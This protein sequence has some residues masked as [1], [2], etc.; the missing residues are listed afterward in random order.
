[1]IQK[2][3]VSLTEAIEAAE[4]SQYFEEGEIRLIQSFINSNVM[5]NNPEIATEK[6]D[7]RAEEEDDNNNEAHLNDQDSTGKKEKRDPVRELFMLQQTE[8]KQFLCMY[9]TILMYFSIN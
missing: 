9:S 6:I 5:V 3:S 7:Y 1:M 8:G 2:K 4:F